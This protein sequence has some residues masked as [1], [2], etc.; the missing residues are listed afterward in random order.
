[1][2]PTF[3]KQVYFEDFAVDDEIPPLVRGPFTVMEMVKFGAMLGDFYPG[4]YDHKWATD[5]DR[6]PGV[7]VYGMLNTVHMSQLLTDWIGAHGM[8]RKFSQRGR[9]QVYVGDTVR[10]T[11]RVTQKYVARG[12]NCLDCE[13]FGHNQDGQL[14][15]DGHATVTLPSIGSGEQLD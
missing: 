2:M 14:V 12:E 8:L 13:M 7:V 10:V 3:G 6:V 9:G 15:E 1:M 5:R 11:G 4:H